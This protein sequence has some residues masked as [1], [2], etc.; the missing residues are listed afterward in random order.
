MHAARLSVT[1][2]MALSVAALADVSS[3]T[4]LLAEGFDASTGSIHGVGMWTDPRALFRVQSSPAAHRGTGFVRVDTTDFADY[5]LPGFRNRWGGWTGFAQGGFVFAPST[6]ER[7]VLTVRGYVRVSMPAHGYTREVRVGIS[8]DDA[9]NTTIADVGMDSSGLLD[10]IALFDGS[11]VLWRT[12]EPVAVAS[13]WNEVLVRLDLGSGLGRVEWN[14]Y[15]LLVFAHAASAVSRVQLI[16]DGRRS[17]VMP[18]KPQGAADFDSVSVAASW[19]CEGDL[20][21][22]RVVDDTDFEAF[23][24]MYSRGECARMTI[25]DASCAA[26][27][28]WDQRVDEDDFA[29][30][31]WRYD[32]FVCP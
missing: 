17:G 25:L 3:D 32:G 22:D 13:E 24:R 31:A 19:H 16:A 14:G 27:F 21:L 6:G 12:A 2:A 20:N 18:I 1:A 5:N 7:A 26:D 4:A 29:I 9:A 15:Q 10:G 28:N 23:V 11:E 30:F 8:V